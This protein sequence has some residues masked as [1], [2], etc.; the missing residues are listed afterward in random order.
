[1]IKFYEDGKTI[2]ESAEIGGINKSTARGIISE[3]KKNDCELVEK[4]RGGNKNNKLSS[5]SINEIEKNFVKN[6]WFD[7][8]VW[9]SYWKLIVLKSHKHE[10]KWNCVFTFFKMS[11]RFIQKIHI[12][13]NIFNVVQ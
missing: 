2:S 9:I 8:D 7:R 6:S 5:E 13:I 10:T 1:M 4:K 11:C 3:Y 12:N